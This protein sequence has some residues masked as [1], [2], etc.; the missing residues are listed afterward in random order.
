MNS[1]ATVPFNTKLIRMLWQKNK[2]MLHIICMSDLGPFTIVINDAT[3]PDSGIFISM[4]C[5]ST[6]ISNEQRAEI[7]EWIGTLDFSALYKG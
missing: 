4:M 5:N 3:Q 2:T 1:Q 7:I 6:I